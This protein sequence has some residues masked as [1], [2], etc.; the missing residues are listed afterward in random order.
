M[1]GEDLLGRR[2]DN[3]RSDP[4]DEGSVHDPAYVELLGFLHVA[5]SHASDS[6]K[7]RDLGA[8]SSTG[9]LTACRDRF[10]VDLEYREIPRAPVADD[11]VPPIRIDPQ[12][13]QVPAEARLVADGLDPARVGH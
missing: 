7:T 5:S 6:A 10:R 3:P 4:G 11:Q 1:V 13:A 9:A 12:C 2:V 8:G